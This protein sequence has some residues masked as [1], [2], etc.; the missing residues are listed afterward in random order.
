VVELVHDR[1]ISDGVADLLLRL[2]SERGLY[3]I[4]WYLHFKH[5]RLKSPRRQDR[6]FVTAASLGTMRKRGLYEVV[7]RYRRAPPIA[8]CSGRS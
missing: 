3:K 6:L 7:H 2:Q 8:L 4:A 1:D 5:A